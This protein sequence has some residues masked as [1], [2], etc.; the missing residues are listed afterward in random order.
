MNVKKIAIATLG[1]ALLAGASLPALAA[2]DHHGRG[3]PEGRG[4]GM[5]QDL[6]FVRLLKM[7]DTN[8]DAKISKEEVTAWQD[9]LFAQI[10]A[11][12]D[13][14]LTRGELIDF[15]AAKM[16]EF[17]KNNPPPEQV[18]DED[19]RRGPPMDDEDD[20]DRAD[21]DR[22]GHH[23][24]WRDDNR[25]DRRGGRDRHEGMGHRAGM[26]S[27]GL[28][29]MIDEDRDGKITKAEAVAASDKL[30]ARMDIN[31]DNQITIDDLPDRP[32]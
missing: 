3:G 12:K 21:R 19:D 4:R 13:G 18:D 31:K 2:P 10:D 14:T 27:R 1:A 6:T 9:Q 32:L 22:P 30:F 5:M 7:A 24:G 8:K 25:D 29:R 17:R 15:R 11:N 23:H 16:D 26:M 20:D 28:F